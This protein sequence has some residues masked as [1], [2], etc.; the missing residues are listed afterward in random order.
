[1]KSKIESIIE[2]RAAP[3]PA[4][5]DLSKEPEAVFKD[6]IMKVKFKKG[7]KKGKSIPVKDGK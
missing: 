2:K 5:V 7:A 3:I 4:A 1:M 6:G